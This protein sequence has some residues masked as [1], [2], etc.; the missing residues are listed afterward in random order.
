MKSRI[1]NSHFFL[2]FVM[3]LAASLSRMLTN[4]LHLWNFTPIAAMALFS[5]ARFRDKRYAFLVP[6]VAMFI[7]DVIIGFHPGMWDVYGTLILITFIGFAL[8]NNVR[9]V[10]VIGASLLSSVIFF[11]I[12]NVSVWVGST[13]YPHTWDGFTTCI[14]AGIPFFGNTVAGDLFYCGVLFGGYELV[15]KMYPALAKAS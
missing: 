3:I 8:R 1:L 7:T 13:L 10:P 6:I 15:K 4:Q 2:L 11:I 14:A 9:I 12:T 5:G